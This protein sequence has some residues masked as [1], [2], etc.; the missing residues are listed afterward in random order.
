MNRATAI[1]KGASL[2]A[3]LT[4]FLL[5]GGPAHAHPHVFVDGGVDFVVEDGDVL[6]ALRVTWLHDAFET[7]YI[8]SSLDMSLNAAG[9]LDPA[10]RQKLVQQRR[11]WP[12]DFDGSAHLSIDGKGV[13]LQWPNSLDADVVDGRLQLTF[14]RPLENPV[15]LTGVVA[16]VAFY[17]ATYFFA[18]S[19]TNTPKILGGSN[20]CH[21]NVIPFNPD[22]QNAELRATLAKLTREETPDIQQVG[23]QFADQIV[24][25]CE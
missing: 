15:D 3:A 10:D 18:F 17:E 2:G 22:T 14:T 1:L 19:V 21:T 7:L 20:N 23:A 16:N 25:Q 11:E 5:V 4:A 24:V 8:L 13:A 9:G 12:S 6:K